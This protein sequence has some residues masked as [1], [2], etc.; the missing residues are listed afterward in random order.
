MKTILR[1]GGQLL[2]GWLFTAV[3]TVVATMLSILTLGL[4][5]RWL[6]PLLLRFWG[7]WIL[8]IQGVQLVIEGREHLA[9]PGTR[10]ATFNHTSLLDA[11]IIP[12]LNPVGGVSLLKREALYIPF[13]GLAVYTLGFL[14]IDRGNSAR[15]RATVN[16]AAHRM[17]REQL[18]VF[19]A[20]EGTRT[21]T[22][23]LQT[24]KRGAFHL[25]LISGAPIVP[26]IITG[27]YALR[28]YQAMITARGTVR[29][30]IL[31]P[32]STVGLTEA[33]LPALASRL[34]AL[35][36]RELALHP[37]AVVA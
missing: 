22:G 18:T 13:V 14:L 31:P 28:P 3:F 36:Q 26:I 25:A 20:P 21:R 23:D 12:V 19:I 17:Q 4:C 1:A 16:R 32:I 11:M 9:Q 35:Y 5:A 2:V 7:R 37:A 29:V 33:G 8:R 27:A 10:I 15:A 30:R 34:H 24:F 6:T